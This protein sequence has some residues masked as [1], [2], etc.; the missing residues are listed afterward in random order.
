[1]YVI[2][3]L[4]GVSQFL[5]YVMDAVRLWSIHFM[6]FTFI[7]CEHISCY[8]K[9]QNPD[10][11]LGTNDVYR[12]KEIALWHVYRDQIST[13]MLELKWRLFRLMLSTYMRT[14][15]HTWS[16]Q[17]MLRGTSPEPELVNVERLKTSARLRGVL[18]AAPPSHQPLPP[19][20]QEPPRPSL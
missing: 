17:G 10:R 13:L 16:E 15:F 18:F 11:N 19:A 7:S 4:K 1:M 14:E 20:V 8:N 2:M 3:S 9:F 5:L 6:Q 12:G